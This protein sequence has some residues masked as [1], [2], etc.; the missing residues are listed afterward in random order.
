MRAS[1]SSSLNM[2]S[3]VPAPGD[4]APYSAAADGRN[5]RARSGQASSRARVVS[6]A[7]RGIGFA[8]RVGVTAQIGR[9]AN[10]VERGIG[11]APWRKIALVTRDSR[12]VRLPLSGRGLYFGVL[13]GADR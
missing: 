7:T 13:G 11:T 5:A 4:G 3:S 1:F 10:S 6:A 12:R 8:P 2:R 9:S